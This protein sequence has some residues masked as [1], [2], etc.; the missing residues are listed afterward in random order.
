M[1]AQALFS[2]S[3]KPKITMQNANR[4]LEF[5][6]ARLHWTLEEWKRVLWSDESRF[7]IWQSDEQIWAWWMPG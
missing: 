5:C 6:K 1:S 4:W 2:A 7:T 3:H